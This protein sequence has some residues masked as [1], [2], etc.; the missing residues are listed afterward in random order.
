M[1]KLNARI[2]RKLAISA[3]IGVLLVAGMIANEQINDAT[4]IRYS[5]TA[6]NSA[7]NA[8]DTQAALIGMLRMRVA[9]GD[10]S[11]ATSASGIEAAIKRLQDGAAEA[12]S[13]LDS[14]FQ[15]MLRAEQRERIK[16][17]KELVDS[18]AATVKQIAE[19]R[20]ENGAVRPID[21]EARPDRDSLATM[22]TQMDELAGQ[23]IS[24]AQERVKG[25][26]ATAKKS[27]LD[28]GWIGLAVGTFVVIILIG[29]AAFAA[30]NI[31]RP[32]GRIGQVLLEIADGNQAIE[33]PYTSRADE[34]G[35]NARAANTFKENLLRIEQMEAE[36]KAA[37]A[38]SAAERKREMQRLADEFQT[39]VG[40]IVGTVSA[41]AEKL[42]GAA[43]SLTH[44][45]ETTQE[46]SSGVAVAS[47]QASANVQSVATATEELTSSVDE[48][49]RQVEDSNKIANEAVKQA[50]ATDGRIAE[51]S[52]SAARI[53]DVVKLI[54]AIA[55]QTNLLALN[56]T[57]E[58]ARAGDSGRGFAVVAQE[59]KALAAQT[60]KATEEIGTQIASMQAATQDS[61]AAIKEI[62]ETI[63]RISHISTN[64]A[65]AV[66]EQGAATQEIARSVQQAAQGT[67]QVASNITSV[68]RGADE[69][70]SASAEVLAAAHS[71]AE[72][73]GHLRAEVD[74][75][76][77]TVRAA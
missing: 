42:E 8:Q 46:L 21:T 38:R 53:G 32:I 41:S 1:F 31:G 39:A 6:F 76:L 48:I 9:R 3:A 11:T 7:G 66:E 24:S 10:V 51:L 27:M 4:V 35:A 14:A 54:T 55:E 58:A 71:L 5:S 37:D 57:I 23:A 67:A 45:A 40:G 62:G 33:I 16:K 73:S 52:R 69:T 25:D 74:T 2:G 61:V 64:V 44:T 17:I 26:A 43:A 30:I 22:A 50:Q 56:A 75:F 15:H 65:A 19:S 28:A 70:G 47:E 49:G 59:V 72:Q 60:A 68:S 36:Q 29:S 12:H 63:G 18:Y 34:V 13:H 20:K 77:A